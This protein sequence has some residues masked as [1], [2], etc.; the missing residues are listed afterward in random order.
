MQCNVTFVSNAKRH[1]TSNETMAS[2]EDF[3][4]MSV[5][6]LKDFLSVHGLRRKKAELVALEYSCVVLKIEIQAT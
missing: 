4:D 1:L 3:D 5:Q 2:M 6:T